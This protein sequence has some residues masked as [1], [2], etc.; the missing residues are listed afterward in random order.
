[1]GP[2]KVNAKSSAEKP[3]S[4]ISLKANWEINLKKPKKKHKKPEED[5]RVKDLAR[6]IKKIHGR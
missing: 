3:K 6:Q 5:A 2:K 4:I 1:M